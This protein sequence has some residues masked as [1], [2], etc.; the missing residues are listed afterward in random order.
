MLSAVVPFSS[1]EA[2][3]NRLIPNIGPS[4][5]FIKII[6]NKFLLKNFSIFTTMNRSGI[7]VGLLIVLG[8]N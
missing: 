5:R 2:N 6:S 1:F 8:K 3:L 4:Q 7:V